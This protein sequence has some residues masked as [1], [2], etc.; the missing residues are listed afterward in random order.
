MVRL[1]LLATRN[2]DNGIIS[3]CDRAARKSCPRGVRSGGERDD[4][5]TRFSERCID[6][7]QGVGDFVSLVEA[8]AA[9]DDAGV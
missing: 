9:I 1:L 2:K 5:P 7:A 8:V 3:A 4:Y 6:P